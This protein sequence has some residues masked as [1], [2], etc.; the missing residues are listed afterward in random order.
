MSDFF[1]F[2]SEIPALTSVHAVP[3]MSMSTG[4]YKGKFATQ[5]HSFGYEGRCALPS[6]FDCSYCYALGYTAGEALAT[7]SCLGGYLIGRAIS[8]VGFGWLVGWQALCFRKT[9]TAQ[10]SAK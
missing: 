1:F 4:K 6:H 8:L 5:F 2:S 9:D 3:D 10:S 7:N